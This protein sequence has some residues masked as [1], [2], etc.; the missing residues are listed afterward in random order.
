MKFYSDG[1]LESFLNNKGATL[2]DI[3]KQTIC[4]KIVYG[5]EYL[6][7]KGII[8][9][10]LKPQNI[11]M[12]SFNPIISDFETSK[13]LTLLATQTMTSQSAVTPFYQTPDNPLTTKSDIYAFGLILF[14][15]FFPRQRRFDAKF[16]IAIPETRVPLLKDMLTLLLSLNQSERPNSNDC[17]FHKFFQQSL[18]NRDSVHDNAKCAIC[19]EDR[20]KEEGVICS[21]ERRHFCCM[22][23]FQ[24]YV[25]SLQDEDIAVQIERKGEIVCPSCRI[26]LSYDAYINFFNPESFRVFI[27]LRE[28]LK[29]TLVISQMN[30]I[31]K[32]EIKRRDNEDQ[33]AM[34]SRKIA[35]ILN[36]KCP[37]CE[38]VFFDFDGCFALICGRCKAGF[39]GWCLQDCARD[40]HSHVEHCRFKISADPFFG[41][42]DEFNESNRQRTIRLI[43]IYMKTID[44]SVATKVLSH[45]KDLLKDLN[46]KFT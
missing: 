2:R 5:L 21:S 26:P 17:L 15:C 14:D 34:H 42:K 41:T 29:E 16:I 4:K 13:D 32:K 22:D 12:S 18:E 27:E 1:D 19:L 23:C 38:T 37:R 39:C 8:H 20:W 3:Q 30:E 6:H 44:A 7:R 46:H 45:C 24:N 43:E 33:V 36:L 9:R 11:L 28:S 25:N 35:D 10:D 40:A 31:H